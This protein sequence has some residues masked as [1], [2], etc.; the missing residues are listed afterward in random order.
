ME[1]QEVTITETTIS[2]AA[3][4]PEP[5]PV[6]VTIEQPVSPPSPQPSAIS[7]EQANAIV[8]LLQT[9]LQAQAELAQAERATFRQQMQETLDTL[10]ASAV[11][12]DTTNGALVEMFNGIDQRIERLEQATAA[13]I[14]LYE[15]W[16]PTTS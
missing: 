6:A 13:L 1:D 4:E 3:P 8:E 9:T 10:Q 14:D 15:L 2:P 16:K 5:Q 7:A 12:L 11:A